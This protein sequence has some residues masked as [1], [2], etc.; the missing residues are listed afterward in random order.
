[1]VTILHTMQALAGAFRLLGECGVQQDSSGCV[2]RGGC[3]SAPPHC[4]VLHDAGAA[5]QQTQRA[6]RYVGRRFSTT[7]SEHCNGHVQLSDDC[8]AA[9]GR[10]SK[11]CRRSWR[12]YSQDHSGCV[13]ADAKTAG[14]LLCTPLK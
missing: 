14:L 1:M 4:S 13:A 8:C 7:S 9:A 12:C 11:L 3:V 10:W 2:V 6:A 5:V